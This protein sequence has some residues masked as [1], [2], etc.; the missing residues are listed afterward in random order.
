MALSSVQYTADGVTD[1]FNIPFG[2]LSKTDIQ[3]RVDGV[4]DESVTFPTDATVQTSA[5]PTN[6]AIVEVKRV[7]PNTNRAVDFQD[8]SLLSEEDLDQSALQN[9]YI[10]QELYDDLGNK[11]GLTSTNVFD[12]QNKKIINLATPTDP[13]DAANKQYIDT[14]LGVWAPKDATYLALSSNGNLTSERIFTAGTGLSGNDGGAG[15]PY[16]LS[17]SIPVSATNGGTGLTA[18]GTANQM[19]GV[20]S[21][22]TGLE[23]KTLTAGSG[24]SVSHGAGTVTVNSTI[25]QY[26]DEMAQDA[27]GGILSDTATIDATYNDGAGT[28]AFDVKDNSISNAKLRDSSGLSILG[29]SANSS[30]DPADIVAASDGDILRRSGTTLGFGSIPSSSVTGLGT[31]ATQNTSNVSI[32]GGE[33]DGI[34]LGNTTPTTILNVDNIRVDGNTISST[35][36]NGGIFIS[37]NG[38]GQVSIQNGPF[39]LKEQTAPATPASTF[40][41]LY[42]KTDGK[43]YWLDDSGNE[44]DL[45][46]LGGG[47]GGGAPTDATYITQT[48]NTGLS[49]EQALSLL[50]TGI[51]QVTTGTG[52]LSSVPAP[53]GDVVGTTDT[54]TLT[55]KKVNP[56]VVA[57][58]SGSTVNTDASTGDLFTLTLAHNATMAAPTN[59]T[60]GQIITYRIQEDTTGGWNLSWDSIFGIL[61]IDAV[62]QLL[63]YFGAPGSGLTAQPFVWNDQSSISDLL[64]GAEAGSV[65]NVSFQ[66]SVT[67]GKW[68]QIQV[69]RGWIEAEGSYVEGTVAGTIEDLSSDHDDISP[70]PGTADWSNPS[71]AL[72]SDDTYA[73]VSLTN[74]EIS[75]WLKVSDF[76]LGMPPDGTAVSC[77]LRLLLEIEAKASAAGDYMVIAAPMMDAPSDYVGNY[78]NQA[79]YYDSDF[80]AMLPLTTS[81]QTFEL[82]MGLFTSNAWAT[83][84]EFGVSFQ[85]VN[86]AGVGTQTISVDR[87][88][89]KA[90]WI[91]PG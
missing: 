15:S 56:R 63:A 64:Q 39:R 14:S 25:T 5:I 73:T 62:A 10:M 54:Q 11:L 19:L 51:V 30:G 43:L 60:D 40:G 91:D 22:A 68:E 80:P 58:T 86:T 81:D 13:Q 83:Q 4:L 6:G 87:V 24:I 12:A 2:Y 33:L 31:M 44:Y 35:N 75:Y 48:P 90:T 23:Y 71:N 18:I 34:S 17:L 69:D 76:D 77:T 20:N 88:R 38:I 41:L 8:G 36:T 50:A 46:A 49:D 79:F 89:L 7:T 3:L 85:I 32:T 9:F 59:P 16:T 21:G 52:V 1:T 72:T 29:R 66:Y 27:V 45:T 82:A 57:L 70:G 61:R 74:G 55:N 84:P 67:S 37:P 42:P 28:L 53:T 78:S 26:T 47:G 65:L